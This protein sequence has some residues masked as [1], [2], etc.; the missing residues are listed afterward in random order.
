VKVAEDV[1]TLSAV[2]AA[3]KVAEC[4]LASRIVADRGLRVG[5]KGCMLAQSEYEIGIEASYGRP[6]K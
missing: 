2:V 6:G 3:S 5:L 4:A 1:A